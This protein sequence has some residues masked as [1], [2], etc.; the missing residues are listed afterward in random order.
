MRYA[1]WLGPTKG[2]VD[3]AR[4]LSWS[5]FVGDGWVRIV[6]V[7]Q[8]TRANGSKVGLLTYERWQSKKSK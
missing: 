8:V 2:K 3:G 1:L 5:D 7:T 6:G 4:N